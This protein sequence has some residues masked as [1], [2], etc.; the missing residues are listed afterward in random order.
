MQR[1]LLPHPV[2]YEAGV[3]RPLR[4]RTPEAFEVSYK[5]LQNCHKQKWRDKDRREEQH[6]SR[7]PTTAGAL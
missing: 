2:Q 5:A 3:L 4:S 6:L 7:N 1:A